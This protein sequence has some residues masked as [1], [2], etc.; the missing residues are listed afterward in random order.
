MEIKK[1]DL[2]RLIRIAKEAVNMYVNDPVSRHGTWVRKSNNF[3]SE[4]ENRYI[5]L[6]Y[7]RHDDFPEEE[8]SSKNTKPRTYFT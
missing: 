2:K 1:T 7:R 3:I 8:T 5:F 6:T 4:V